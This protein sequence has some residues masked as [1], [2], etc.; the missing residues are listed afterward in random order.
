MKQRILVISGRK[1]A[2]KNTLANF[3]QGIVL[4]Q[5][6]LIDEFE[7]SERS[8]GELLIKRGNSH[9]ENIRK[10]NIGRDLIQK[11]EYAD[12]LKNIMST[13][14]GISDA[15]LNGSDDDKNTLTKYRWENMPG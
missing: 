13:F 11:Y 2:G 5:H 4:L 15:Q 10:L 1:Q 7:V 9:Y 3:L 8:S 14:F 12:Q 6:G